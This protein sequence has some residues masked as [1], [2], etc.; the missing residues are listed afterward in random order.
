[1]SSFPFKNSE[2]FF[3]S[4]VKE[5]L[6]YYSVLLLLFGVEHTGY[7][8]FQECFPVYL[9]QLIGLL[10]LQHKLLRL[11]SAY[12]IKFHN[13]RTRHL[14][15]T[16]ALILTNKPLDRKRVLRVACGILDLLTPSNTYM[17]S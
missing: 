7:V 5:N 11:W 1:M 2:S 17:I 9:N 10:A 13:D 15:T 3:F 16:I 4:L 14:S 12:T 6:L 8:H